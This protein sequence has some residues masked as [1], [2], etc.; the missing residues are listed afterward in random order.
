MTRAR[1]Y[2]CPQ[3]ATQSGAIRSHRWII[4]YGE[5]SP[6]SHDSLTGWISCNDTQAEIKLLFATKEQAI[7]YAKIHS[8]AYDIEEP[9]SNHYVI[10][11][12]EDNFDNNRKMNWTH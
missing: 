6:R 7:N 1:I 10:K 12:Y 3:K 11:N 9:N 4:D 8:I 2:K 5:S